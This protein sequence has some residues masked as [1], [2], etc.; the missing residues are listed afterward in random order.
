M[1]ELFLV[2]ATPIFYLLLDDVNVRAS[3]GALSQ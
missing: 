1:G 3:S 2:I